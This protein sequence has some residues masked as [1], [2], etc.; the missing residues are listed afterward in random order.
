M[1]GTSSLSSKSK[2]VKSTGEIP[3]NEKTTLIY[4]VD[5]W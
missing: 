5:L 3:K 4:T 2:N 1:A